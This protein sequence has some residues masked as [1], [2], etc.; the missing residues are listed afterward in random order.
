M[1]GAP[2]GSLYG[3]VGLQREALKRTAGKGTAVALGAGYAGTLSLTVFTPDSL[4]EWLPAA[5]VSSGSISSG[6]IYITD[7]EQPEGIMMA[8]SSWHDSAPFPCHWFIDETLEQGSGSGGKF[9]QITWGGPRKKDWK[10]MSAALIYSDL[11]REKK[12]DV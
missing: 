7:G 11:Y 5:N 12:H 4:E 3:C 1:G 8:L 2:L 10:G 9:S 6:W